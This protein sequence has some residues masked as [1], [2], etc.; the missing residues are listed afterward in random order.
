MSALAWCCGVGLVAA[1]LL[2]W[3][4]LHP[5]PS[6]PTPIRRVARVHRPSDL[7]ERIALGAAGAL[8]FG[9]A[10]GWPVAAIGGAVLG[11]FAR[12]VLA[13]QRI[14]EVPI[15]RTEA[16]A[17]WAEQLRDTMAGAA[18]LQE[19]IVATAPLA[20]RPI[21]GPVEVMARRTAREP[22]A[23][24][25]VELADEL[26][27]PT[28][29]L[30]CSALVL[31]ASGDGQDLGEVLSGLA[32]SARDEATMRRFVDAS[33]ARTR[34]AVRAITAITVISVL[35]LFLFAHPYLQP[36]GSFTGQVV[37]GVVF[38]CYGAGIALL[39]KMS[40]ERPPERLLSLERQASG[41]PRGT[42]R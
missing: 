14:R 16:I 31:A 6:A 3:S 2:A 38:G 30:V 23:P 29:D 8:V 1:I 13:P 27:D 21:R 9:L 10:T 28:A 17:G 12:E 19:A 22:L 18:G 34:T 37:L 42:Q 25:L 20:P 24:L 7:A 11:V 35:L 4:G 39:V 33:R 36:Y 5:V 32:E 40:R 26:S 41:G 15:E